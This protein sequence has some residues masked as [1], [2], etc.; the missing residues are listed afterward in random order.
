MLDDE[1]PDA[2]PSEAA[3]SH[4]APGEGAGHVIDRYTLVEPVGEGGMGTVWMAEQSQPVKRRV[5][6]KIIKLGMDTREVVVRFE[7]ER[8][9]LALMDHPCIAKVLDGGAT[10]SGRPYFVMELVDGVPITQFCDEHRLDL[11]ARLELFAKVCDA[12]Q[13][14]H[15]KGIIHRDI[16]PSNVLVSLGDDGPTPKVIDFG[17]AKAT[18]AELTE[19]TLATEL[20]QIVGTPEY[21]APEQAGGGGLDIDTR[22]DVY[23]L[24]VLLYELLTGTKTFDVRE[25]LKAGYDE[26]LRQIR[27]IDPA[28]PST[29]VSSLGA[30][31]TTIADTRLVDAATLSQRLR[32]ELDWVV[33]RAIEKDRE[34][35]YDTASALADDV[36]RYLA[37]EP[38]EAAP[39]SAMYR[40]RKFVQRRRKTVA[41][42]A[43][44]AF[45]LVTGVVGTSVGLVWAL[46]E[47]DRA[48]EAAERATRSAE[49][50]ATA[51]RVARE[52]EQRAIAEAERA[53]AA[54]AEEVRARKRAETVTTFVTETL[55]RSSALDGGHEDMTVLEAMD[56]AVAEIDEGRFS[57]DPET[58]AQL[59][60]TVAEILDRNGRAQDALPLLVRARD[61]RRTL[62]V[63][64]DR[65]LVLAQAS[66][67][68][69]LRDL[70]RLTE[71]A[72]LLEEAVEIDRR[73]DD[74]HGLAR[75][76]VLNHLAALRS[77]QGRRTEAIDI[78]REL[79]AR[80]EAEDSE[81]QERFQIAILRHNLGI[82]LVE[83]GQ[84]GEAE[85]MLAR[86]LDEL[87]LFEEGDDP[88]VALFMESLAS[89][90]A[91][92]GN[93]D[94]ALDLY[95]ASLAMYRAIYSGPHPATAQCLTNFGSK[96]LELG[97]PAESEPY[98]RE[99]LEMYRAVYPSG[100]RD[101]ARAHNFVA[102]ALA[103]QRR[104]DEVGPQL[105]AC[106][107]IYRR[108]L[109]EPEQ[110]MARALTFLASQR[111]VT[112]RFDEA[113]ELYAEAVELYRVLEPE[114]APG[115]GREVNDAFANAAVLAWRTG[116][117][118]RSVPLFEELLARHR[119]TLEPEDP[120]L[121][122]AAMNLGVNLRDAGRAAEAV[123]LLEEARPLDDDPQT[124]GAVEQALLVTYGLAGEVEKAK[125][126]AQARVRA[127]REVYAPGSG[128]LLIVLGDSAAALVR[129][130]E[131]ADAEAM[132]VE[133][134]EAID[135]AGLSS[136]GT[137]VARAQLGTARL[138]LGRADEAE[139]LLLA[140]RAG[141]E[142]MLGSVM[143][144]QLLSYEECLGALVELYET[145]GDEQ[146]AES[147][148][149]ALETWRA[150]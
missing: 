112:G 27:E 118:D 93:T 136:W 72:P 149:A 82:A 92:I 20:G 58:E 86:A 125:S 67:G 15:Q 140:G 1:A 75:P 18:S 137:H 55:R 42:L 33:M 95:D 132:L 71:A 89:A 54:A 84:S 63:G 47:R 145:L 10:T 79:L 123:P 77:A 13:H 62:A 114:L 150:R 34:R 97:A 57:D 91:A 61:L 94:S 116:R 8:Q 134:V 21:M 102:S 59:L 17:I 144:S 49:A 14:A 60:G 66:L 105:E 130:G 70:G 40:W 19:A 64:D 38:V 108:V 119:A 146:Q 11:R 133:M 90:R 141:M 44:I 22:A 96:L 3:P 110:A 138:A 143:P 69:M 43:A 24:G 51:E 103:R 107:A 88:R 23:S 68:A 76:V 28:L 117:L 98:F 74:E 128:E 2:A 131:A 113:Y 80:L 12:I 121:L 115:D 41:A 148:R 126:L 50:A 106:V 4:A 25:A 45:L 111:D 9:A 81:R 35:R 16:K 30:T 87:R 109:E 48:D 85:P 7:A 5:A 127:A 142:A 83:E 6:L 120:R 52:N 53:E 139:Q 78:Y 65:A 31:A 37:N 104:Y 147:V 46:D 101:T 124:S 122:I 39:P 56:I 135:A 36:G 100:H 26:L 29:R 99:A 32:G 73:L 129:V